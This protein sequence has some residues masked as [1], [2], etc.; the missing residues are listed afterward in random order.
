MLSGYQMQYSTEA[1]YKV[2]YEYTQPRKGMAFLHSVCA[3]LTVGCRHSAAPQAY[4]I[5]HTYQNMNSAL[6]HSH[7]TL[8]TAMYVTDGL[9][10]AAH[11]HIHLH[12]HPRHKD[13]WLLSIGG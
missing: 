4:A 6:E 11:Q 7:A 9:V 1:G 13:L 8:M 10:T 12:N 5:H 3:R 2:L